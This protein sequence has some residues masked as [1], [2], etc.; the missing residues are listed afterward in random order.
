MSSEAHYVADVADLAED[1]QRVV[2]DV[3]GREIAVF[4]VD[5][6]Y[7]AL[8][9]FCVHQGGPLCEGP[10]TGR[11]DVADDGRWIYDE[12]DQVISC[13]WHAWR[14]DI[15]TGVNVQDDRYTIPKYDV[16][17]RDGQ[18]FV[19]FEAGSGRP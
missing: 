7:H 1:G 6:E 13:P 9:N 14:F 10:L 15:E 18:I 19:S 8:L 12:E 4:R 11:S 17:V 2:V 3:D 5:G 16:E